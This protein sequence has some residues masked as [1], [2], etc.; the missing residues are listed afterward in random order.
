MET[1][2]DGHAR[3]KAAKRAEILAAAVEVFFEEGYA[4]ASMDRIIDKIG[5]SKRTIYSYFPS[6]EELF[7]A[8]VRDTADRILAALSPPLDN[9]DIREN[10]VIM[11][12]RYVDVLLSREGLALF[13]AVVAEAAYFPE[14]AKIFS[15]RGSRRVMQHLAAFFDKEMAKG[16]IHVDE[17]E[18]AAEQFL[19]MVIGS[20]HVRAALSRDWRP[21]KRDVSKRVEQAVEIFLSYAATNARTG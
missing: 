13:R 17:P 1:A 7:G 20:L 9:E 16:V 19:G 11:A 4:R 8:I 12:S 2:L 15:E 5:G 10:L 3:R 14:L 6:K 18:L 21:S